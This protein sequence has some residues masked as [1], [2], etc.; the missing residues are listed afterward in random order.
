M[1]FGLLPKERAEA[2]L[3]LLEGQ[4]LALRGLL[5]Q[6]GSAAL[7]GPEKISIYVFNERIPYTEFVN[8]NENRELEP[9]TEAHANFGV[10]TPYIAAVDPLTLKPVSSIT[11]PTLLAIAARV[12]KTR[13]IDNIMLAAP[14]NTGA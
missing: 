7:N 12:G 4:Y 8:G 9:G 2:T 13:L 10:E 6:P 5:G 1:L 11:I 3:K 14:A